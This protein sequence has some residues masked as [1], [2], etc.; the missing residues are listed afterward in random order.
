MFVDRQSAGK[1]LGH[2]LAPRRFPNPVILA[3]PRGGVPVAFEVAKILQAPLD[4]LVVRKIGAPINPEFAIG[5]ISENDALVINQLERHQ[6]GVSDTQLERLIAR[7]RVQLDRRIALYRRG[8]P[9]IDLVGRTVILIDDGMATGSTA[10]AAVITLRAMN[11]GQIVVA[12]P[13]ASEEAVDYLGSLADE[14]ISLET[15]INFGS[16]GQRYERFNEISDEEVQ[17]YLNPQAGSASVNV[18]QVAIDQVIQ[19]PI[20][21]GDSLPGSL[22]IPKGSLGLVVFAHGSG[23]SRLS[24]RNIAVANALQ[25]DGLGTLLFDLLTE[26]EALDRRN[27]FDIQL[28]AQ[29]L[30]TARDWLRNQEVT[31]DLALSYFGA[32]T[33]AAAA[34]VAAANDH[35]IAAIV[36]RGGRADLA[37]LSLQLVK[38]PTLLIVG[39]RDHEVL[40]LNRYAKKHLLCRSDMQIVSGA[41]HLFEEPGTLS[42]VA[43]LASQWFHKY[44]GS[45]QI[46]SHRSA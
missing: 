41:T 13:T 1:Q 24:E 4:V 39:G 2:A 8:K 42:E 36:S 32:S 33:G 22:T 3:L 11:T 16:V 17:N 12:V 44:L 18:N 26:Q 21:H 43:K 27:V 14:V 23:S 40:E 28:L 37:G 15:P 10:A 20:G 46:V 45:S 31:R 34:L 19:I 6:L 7:Q 29:R 5:A 9:L 38:A 25:R 30:I 35:T